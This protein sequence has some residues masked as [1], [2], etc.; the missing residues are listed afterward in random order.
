ML[1]KHRNYSPMPWS[2]QG[3]IIQNPLHKLKYP[4]IPVSVWYCGKMMQ[5]MMGS[6][7]SQLLVLIQVALLTKMS[8]NNSRWFY[9]TLSSSTIL[10][11]NRLCYYSMIFLMNLFNMLLYTTWMNCLKSTN[12]TFIFW[13]FSWV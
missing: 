12:F 5:F 10:S 7:C 11:Q 2:Y 1:D 6:K 13:L 9:K 3:D 4:K 8:W